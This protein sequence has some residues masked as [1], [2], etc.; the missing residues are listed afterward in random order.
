[1][2]YDEDTKKVDIFG[3]DKDS[4]A[5]KLKASRKKQEDRLKEILRD[6]G[7]PDRSSPAVKRE[8]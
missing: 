1:M 3:Y 2:P 7:T 6:G 4:T 8:D 5:G